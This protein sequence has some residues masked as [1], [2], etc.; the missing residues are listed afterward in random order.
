M[1]IRSS[2][3]T[4]LLAGFVAWTCLGCSRS[5]GNPGAPTLVPPVS[6]PQTVS[7]R[8]ASGNHQPVSGAHVVVGGQ[9]Y[10]TDQNGFIP[11]LPRTSLGADVD[12]QVAG[13]LPRATRLGAQ[14]DQTVTL[15]PIANDAEADAVHHMVFGS[16][17]GDPDLLYPFYSGPFFLTMPS[18]DTDVRTAWKAGAVNFGSVF[19]ITYVMETQFQY[20]ENEIS[21]SFGPDHGCM[22][23]SSSGLC[24]ASIYYKDFAVATDRA[25]D[26]VTI[27]RVLASL[28]LG[29]NPF[30][31]LLN[32]DAP[33]DTLS[34]F[35]MQTILMILQRPLKTRW[36]DNDRQ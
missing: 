25:T 27:R 4:I 24:R 2:V 30:P 5:T 18:A 13:Y 29:P 1:I 11:P 26:P 9:E 33:A 17:G 36:P 23:A 34:P 28:F 3:L 14:N 32:P 7:V 12:V 19:G 20:D 6:L 8:I 16:T 10:S 15:W 31:G 22:P 21:V 35:E